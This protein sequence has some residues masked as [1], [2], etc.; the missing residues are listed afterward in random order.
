MVIVGTAKSKWLDVLSGIPQG[1]VLGPLLFVMYIKDLS[2]E[3]ISITKLFADD[4]KLLSVVN[5]SKDSL[6]LQNDID[7]VCEW[8]NTW[9]MKLFSNV[10]NC[11][12]MHF[13]K[14]TQSYTYFMGE[15]TGKD[16]N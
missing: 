15:T 6:S 16:V 11:K 8:S 1:S 3:V 9:G 7:R 13:G 2:D 10:S 12:V 14:N 4:S 5:E